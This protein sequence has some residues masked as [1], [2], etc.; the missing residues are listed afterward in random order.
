MV[1]TLFIDFSDA[2]GQLTLKS[3]MESSR[4]SNSSKL[5]WM[6]L[7]PA[8]MKKIHPKN[9][10]TRV[11]TTFLPLLVYGDF[12]RCSRAANSKVSDQI[13]PNFKSILDFMVV[14]VSCKN[15][16]LPI[17]IVGARVVTRFSP[18]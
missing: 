17:K 4:I 1:T 15:K 13:L 8:R 2:K 18:L 10:G 6:V 12:A 3:E 7:L 16:E 11:V 5:L 9:E 14:L